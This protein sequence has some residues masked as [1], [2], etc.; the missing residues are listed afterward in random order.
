MPIEVELKAWVEDEDAL[1]AQLMAGADYVGRSEKRDV[2]YRRADEDP[3]SIDPGRSALPRLRQ[4]DQRSFVTLKRKRRVDGAE[5]NDEIEFAVDPTEA[6]EAFLA[7]L[8][9]L[10]LI[11]KQKDTRLFRDRDERRLSYELNVLAGLGTFIELELLLDSEA[12]EG[13]VTAARAILAERMAR[14]GVAE[15]AIEPRYYIELLRG[16]SGETP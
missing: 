14:L 8:G 9:F 5:V 4:V 3:D 16:R 1:V 11:A 13:E 6:A 15:S 10:P 2:Y 12:S 7:A